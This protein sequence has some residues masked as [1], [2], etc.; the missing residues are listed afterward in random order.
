MFSGSQC[1]LAFIV[2]DWCKE[3]LPSLWVGISSR[4]LLFIY[5]T[6]WIQEFPKGGGGGGGGGV[7]GN[8]WP[9]QGGCKRVLVCLNV[10]SYHM[11]VFCGI[12]HLFIAARFFASLCI[13]RPSYSY[14]I[15][16]RCKY[17][18]SGLNICLSIHAVVSLHAHFP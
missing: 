2:Y 18:V 16:M 5:A 14:L 12:L 9:Q 8:A 4:L 7:N 3:K 11:K 13:Q 17:V 1:S 6:E 10:C 15:L